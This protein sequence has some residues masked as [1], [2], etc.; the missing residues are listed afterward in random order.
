MSG[1]ALPSAELLQEYFE[2]LQARCLERGIPTE[3]LE[4][5][6]RGW[7]HVRFLGEKRAWD[8]SVN[9][10]ES[11]LRLP[12]VLLDQPR[13]LLPHVGYLGGVCVDDGE[14]MS[15]DWDRHGEVV[16]YTFLEAFLQLE[17]WT[18]DESIQTS[19]FFNELEA[20]WNGLPGALRGRSAF[21][22]DEVDRLITAHVKDDVKKVDGTGERKKVQRWCFTERGAEIPK[23]FFVDSAQ[24]KRGLYLHFP[25]VPSPPV[26]PDALTA[27]FLEAVRARL[28]APQLA[29]WTEFLSTSKSTSKQLV[30]FISTP[31][32]AGGRSL[33]GVVFS[34]KDH[35]V[36]AD[37]TVTPIT[38]RRQ[39]AAY[40]RERGGASLEL[41]GK[42][43]AVLGCGAVGS[44]VADTLASAGVGRLTLVDFDVFSEDNV[45]RHVLD[46][47]YVGFDKVW[48]LKIRLEQQYS[49]L[50]VDVAVKHAQDWLCQDV[51]ADLDGVVLAIGSP[52]LERLLSRR[53]KMVQRPLPVVFTWLEAMDLGGHSVLTSTRGEG[54]LECLYRDEEGAQSLLPRTAFLEQNQRVTRNLT[55]CASVFVPYGALQARRTGLMA[56][57]QLLGAIT[58]GTR[59]P[60]YQFWVGAGTAAQAQGLKTTNWWRRAPSV[61]QAEATASVFGRACKHCRGHV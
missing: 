44:F 38:V 43:V 57:E 32:A 19:E 45:F 49:G 30:L 25:E 3:R 51:L 47:R 33:I 58:H 61:L 10:A 22:V 23:V 9:C 36:Q 17:K 59:A 21:E 56:A 34:A 29:L 26:F 2:L 7:L 41:L 24:T 35:Q 52:T 13:G 8:L 5:S 60:A 53:F 39:T 37:Q 40:M 18:A 31:R 11:G 12:G 42:H 55:G 20:Y 15:L 46:E 28:S 6:F 16:A 4:E 27:D 54:C 1:P 50:K 48:G 14:G